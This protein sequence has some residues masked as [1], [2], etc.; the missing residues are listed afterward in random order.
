MNFLKE[1]KLFFFENI[2]S[3]NENFIIIWFVFESIDFK[4]S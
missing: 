4:Y 1:I 2:C 3:K